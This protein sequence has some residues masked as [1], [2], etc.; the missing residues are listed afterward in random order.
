[1]CHILMATHDPL[2]FA[3]LTKEQVRILRRDVDGSLAVE[4]PDENPQ[5]MGIEAILTSELFR[6]RTTLDRPTQLLLDLQRRLSMQETPLNDEERRLLREVNEKLEPLG[7]SKTTR[8]PLY[9]L[10]LK[11]WT[12]E[13][14]P[15]WLIATQLTEEQRLARAQLAAKIVTRLRA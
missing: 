2:L 3:S 4:V 1:N 14:D 8:D 5:G 10:F 11:A 12:A 6:L 7:F 15:E 9:E 13:E